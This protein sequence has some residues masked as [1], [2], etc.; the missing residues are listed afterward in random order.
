MGPTTVVSNANTCKFIPIPRNV[1]HLRM[2][3]IQ[4]IRFTPDVSPN[5]Q[6]FKPNHSTKFPIS[7]EIVQAIARIFFLRSPLNDPAFNFLKFL[8]A[9]REIFKSYVCLAL[10][11][12]FF[13]ALR[14]LLPP[15]QHEPT[16]T[17][18]AYI[19]IVESN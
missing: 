1:V 17:T 2:R 16:T 3:N 12:C 15:S 18:R 6:L 11:C 10:D 4:I 14:R 9:S 5:P 7:R 8:Q 13:P 19:W